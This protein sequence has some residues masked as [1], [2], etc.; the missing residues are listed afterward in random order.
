MH[1]EDQP[2]R[3][4]LRRRQ[5]PTSLDPYTTFRITPSTCGDGRFASRCKR[6]ADCRLS[7]PLCSVSCPAAML[8]L[9][10]MFQIA[11]V[12]LRP[13]PTKSNLLPFIAKGRSPCNCVRNNARLLLQSAC[14]GR[15]IRVFI[16][17]YHQKSLISLYTY[18]SDNYIGV[19]INV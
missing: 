11:C 17:I 8:M 16:L 18:I 9:L 4:H 13:A 7:S 14:M 19:G 3:V 1:L 12:P 2:I 15:R 10:S 6:P 5:P